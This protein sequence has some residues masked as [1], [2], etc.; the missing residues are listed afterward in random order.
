VEY[1]YQI[2]WHADE[3]AHENGIYVDLKKN[4]EVF[5]GY[6]GQNI[7]SVIYGENCFS[8]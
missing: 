4:P 7:W 3:K 8:G 6:Q 2:E 5:T 1:Q